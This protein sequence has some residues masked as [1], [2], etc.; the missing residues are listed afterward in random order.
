MLFFYVFLGTFSA[1]TAEKS[2]PAGHA[3]CSAWPYEVDR[4]SQHGIQWYQVKE[5]KT[6]GRI[7]NSTFFL[8]FWWEGIR[9]Q[10]YQFDDKLLLRV[11]EISKRLA[12]SLSVCLNKLQKSFEQ[13]YLAK[14]IE[15]NQLYNSNNAK[16]HATRINKIFS[17]NDHWETAQGK[18]LYIISMHPGTE[19]WWRL[20]MLHP[21]VINN[22]HFLWPGNLSTNFTWE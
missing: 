9:L 11:S 4:M 5:T 7:N 3:W 1:Q 2:G 13:V 16:L 22:H 8:A 14:Q 21:N 15:N 12:M 6:S 17:Q 19:T 20:L 18:S 10:V